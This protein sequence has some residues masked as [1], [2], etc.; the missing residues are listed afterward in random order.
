MK[1]HI[2]VCVCVR[3]TFIQTLQSCWLPRSSS[4]LRVKYLRAAMTIMAHS[5]VQWFHVSCGKAALL[6]LLGELAC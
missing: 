1:L 5:M 2:C 4:G 6:G 3:Y